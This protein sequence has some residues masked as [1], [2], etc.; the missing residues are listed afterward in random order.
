[1][2][3]YLNTE[4]Y[5]NQGNKLKRLCDTLLSQERDNIKIIDT[6]LAVFALFKDLNLVKEKDQMLW[7]LIHN[8][9][10][11]ERISK[12][13]VF[14]YLYLRSIFVINI[15]SY[16]IEFENRKIWQFTNDKGSQM[17]MKNRF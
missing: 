9:K 16:V 7:K 6:I 2:I 17:T 5:D 4:N 13:G 15:V 10:C 14:S 12:S 3:N 8:Y 1:M 11:N